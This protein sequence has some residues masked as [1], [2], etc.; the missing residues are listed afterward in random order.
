MINLMFDEW[1]LFNLILGLY[2][3][4]VVI[5]GVMVI[6]EVFFMLIVVGDV[7]CLVKFFISDL[8]FIQLSILFVVGI[9]YKI[10][11]VMVGLIE[12]LIV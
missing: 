4:Q 2:V 7:F 11:F 5:F 8:V 3:Q 9:D 6:G 10:E 12:F 1:L